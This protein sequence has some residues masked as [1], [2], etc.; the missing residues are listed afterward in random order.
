M[1]P[2]T[3]EIRI[4][5]RSAEPIHFTIDGRSVFKLTPVAAERLAENLRTAAGSVAPSRVGWYCAVRRLNGRGRW[6]VLVMDQSDCRRFV[7]VSAGA[8]FRSP[9]WVE[10]SAC[11]DWRKPKS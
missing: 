4:K 9:R 8:M 3:V 1:N 10:L 6:H 7:K 11:E 5:D 2:V